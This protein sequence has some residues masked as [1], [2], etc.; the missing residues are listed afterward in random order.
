MAEGLSCQQM[1]RL[2]IGEQTTL[3]EIDTNKNTICQKRNSQ[4]D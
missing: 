2:F 1:S 3:L 4:V